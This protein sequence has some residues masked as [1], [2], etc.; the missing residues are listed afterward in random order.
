M[1]S[2]YELTGQYKL[3]MDMMS[4]SDAEEQVIIDTL[5]AITGEIE[6]K[7]ENY[8]KVINTL[9]ADYEALM[10]EADR[11][12]ARA[13]VIDN[14]IKRMKAALLTAMQET[15]Q[16][17]IDTGLFQIKIV[18]NGGVRPL[19]IDGEVPQSFIKMVPQNDNV[20][21]RKYIEELEKSGMACNWAH[22]GDRGVH[23]QI[24]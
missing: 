12:A 20:N 14:R 15:D 1:A 4:D 17:K 3:L 5:G 13:A 10:T 23:L 16:Q 11:F 22:L 2:L 6:V 7:A 21:I 8:V 9:E 18:G 19:V 24:K